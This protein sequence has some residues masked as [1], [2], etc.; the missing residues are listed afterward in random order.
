VG[1]WSL[2]CLQIESRRRRIS[3]LTQVRLDRDLETRRL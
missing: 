1:D 2:S 3:V